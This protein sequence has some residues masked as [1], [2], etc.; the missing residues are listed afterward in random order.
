MCYLGE[1]MKLLYF[2]APNQAYSKTRT[3]P[4][5]YAC[6]FAGALALI[7]FKIFMKLLGAA[8]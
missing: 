7:Q 2:A 4:A 1:K 8:K 3:V 5:K 6:D